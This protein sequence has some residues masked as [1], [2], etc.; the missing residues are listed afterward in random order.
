MVAGKVFDR[1]N[2]TYVRIKDANALVHRTIKGH[3][4]GDL[5]SSDPSVVNAE[6]LHGN[7]NPLVHAEIPPRLSSVALWS[8]YHKWTELKPEETI[9]TVS[10]VSR[11]SKRSLDKEATNDSHENNAKVSKTNQQKISIEK[12]TPENRTREMA[13]RFEIM[14]RI[15][16]D[17]VLSRQMRYNFRELKKLRLSRTQETQT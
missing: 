3:I 12:I 17:P 8:P 5:S 7:E 4:T 10:G 13:K 2:V 9:P 6:L 11:G 14:K 15:W 1:F 16:S